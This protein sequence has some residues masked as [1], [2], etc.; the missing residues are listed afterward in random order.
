MFSL[1]K[2][3]QDILISKK[4]DKL[5]DLI[6]EN[7]TH[8]GRPT[9]L[10]KA[11][12]FS[13]FNKIDNPPENSSSTTKQEV[14]YVINNTKDL[15]DA[16]INTILLIDKDPLVIYKSFL[17]TKNLEFPQQEFDKLYSILHDLIKDI[18]IH[19]NRPRPIQIAEF[20]DLELTVIN[21]NTHQTPSYPSGHVAYATLAEILLS[22]KYPEFSSYFKE[23][24]E[25]VKL[26]RIKQGVHFPSDNEAAYSFVYKIFTSL[27]KYSQEL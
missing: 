18:K 20:H 16:A 23:A 15:S 22:Y 13:Y 24:T 5:D 21:T 27:K 9:D 6:Y 19:Y 7:Y 2:K 11:L 10:E 3:I 4:K 17:K 8:R 14:E 12:S 26:A 25:K 1:I